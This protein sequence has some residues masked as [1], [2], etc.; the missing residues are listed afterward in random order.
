MAQ[1]IAIWAEST[2]FM[3]VDSA[4]LFLI[5]LML[6]GLLW[7]VLNENN[8]VRLTRGSPLGSV[9]KAALVGLPLPLCSCSVLPVAT[10]L[11][12]SGVGKAGVT[13]FLISTPEIGIDSILLT[14]SLTD[15]LLTVAR[16]VSAFVAAMTAGLLEATVASEL[17]PIESDQM[18]GCHESCDCKQGDE[19]KTN[20]RMPGRLVSGIRYAF[21]DLL[22]DLAPYLAVG[23]VLAGLVGA[24]LGGNL[25]PSTP[26]VV[27]GWM[28]YL[29]AIVIGLPL[30]V[31]ATSSTPL[32]AAMLGA[33][34][35]PGAILVFL[36]VGPA[37]NVASLV[38]LR[39]VLGGWSTARYVFAVILAAVLCG[40]A[41]DAAY[42]LLDL[43]PQYDGSVSH[44]SEHSAVQVVAALLLAVLI[45]YYTGRRLLKRWT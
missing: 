13:A 32:A 23:F 39:R 16:P 15:P 19:P 41:T 8:I 34:F 25:I 11:R 33:G 24:V 18:D 26:G 45:I 44:H 30:Y 3:L 20:S 37:T 35:A 31:C 27:G 12:K 28:G 40:L 21:T 4:L 9:F 36:L 1:F 6:A 29:W 10:Q 7:L 22:S 38:V 2:W 17:P 5:G 43:A 42:R 14:Y